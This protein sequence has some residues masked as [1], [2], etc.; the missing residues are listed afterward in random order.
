MW[1]NVRAR[2]ISDQKIG[3]P[4]L[5]W[6]LR[7]AGDLNHDGYPDLLLCNLINAYALWFWDGVQLK[8]WWTMG[9]T[10]FRSSILAMGDWNHDGNTDVCF[11][12]GANGM[13]SLLLGNSG[14]V[15][16][17]MDWVTAGQLPA[18]RQIVGALN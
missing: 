9:T 13:T 18:G 12:N 7:S 16:E 5:G 17:W 2:V 15:T 3:Q 6:K 14:P 8:N 4:A 1:D 10:K 11:Q